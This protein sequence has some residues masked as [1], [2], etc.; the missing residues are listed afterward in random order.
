MHWKHSEICF[1]IESV[2]LFIYLCNLNAMQHTLCHFVCMWLNMNLLS[3]LFDG[4]LQRNFR[5]EGNRLSGEQVRVWVECRDLFSFHPE[6]NLCKHLWLCMLIH[7]FW[8]IIIMM[9]LSLMFRSLLCMW[10]TRLSTTLTASLLATK[11]QNPQH[12]NSR[13]ATV[14]FHSIHFS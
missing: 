6:I 4:T 10:I 14:S 8:W 13:L 7:S 9:P 12:R 3:T 5:K 2:L 1:E 11:Y